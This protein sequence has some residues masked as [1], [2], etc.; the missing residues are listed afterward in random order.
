MM[1]A[2]APLD[3]VDVKKKFFR[4]IA[5]ETHEK[6]HVRKEGIWINL[7]DTDREGWSLRDGEMQYGPK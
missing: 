6:G 5:D 2:N 4:L 7:V 3:A 1:L